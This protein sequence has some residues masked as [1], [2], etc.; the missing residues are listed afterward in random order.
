[1]E[2]KDLFFL[3]HLRINRQPDAPSPC[4]CFSVYFL[5][6]TSSHTL[7]CNHHNHKV[8]TDTTLQ[9]NPQTPIVPLLSFID[10]VHSH[11][12]HWDVLFLVSFRLEQFCLSLSFMAL[13]HLKTTG[14]LFYRM[15]LNLELSDVFS[16]LNSGSASLVGILQKQ[17]WDLIAFPGG[18]DFDLFL[19]RECQL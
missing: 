10:L 4:K 5:Q 9:F 18:A 15:S 13:R 2:F 7:Q 11:T 1:M 16:W 8:N 19:Y 12:L 14:Q 6:I 17:C 3:R